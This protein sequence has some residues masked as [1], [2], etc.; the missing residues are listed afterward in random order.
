MLSRLPSCFRLPALLVLLALGGALLARP[1]QAQVQR[2]D[3]TPNPDDVPRATGAYAIEDARVVVAPGDTLEGATVVVRDGLI[4]AVGRDVDAPYDAAAVEEATG[5]EEDDS[6]VVHAGFI[7]GLSH[8]GIPQSGSSEE[9]PDVKRPGAPPPEVAGLQADRSARALLDPEE[10]T[11]EDLRA[12]GFTAAH[13][14]PRSGML[15]GQG[16]VIQLA[17]DSPSGMVLR[18]SAS[19]FA[20]FEGA[21]RVYPATDMAVIATVR[22]LLREAARRQAL[23]ERYEEAPQDLPRPRYDDLHAALS[24]VLAG[25]KPMFF[26]TDGALGL[27]RATRLHEELGFP[28]AMAGLQQ[29]F[30]ATET[31]TEIQSE[32]D[33]E[34]ADVPLFLSLALPEEPDDAPDATPDTAR[35]DSVRPG[36]VSGAVADTTQPDSVGVGQDTTKAVSP[37][38]PGSP[39]IRDYRTRSYEDTDGE[40]ENLLARRGLFAERYYANAAT[41]EDAGLQFGFSTKEADAGDIHANLRKMI[42]YGLSEED[43]LAALTTDAARLLGLSRRLGTVE[44]GKI[45]NLVVTDGALFEEDTAIR[46]VFVDGEPFEYSAE[47]AGGSEGEAPPAEGVN[48][49]GTW[50][51]EISAPGGTQTGTLTLEGAPGNLSGTIVTRGEEQTLED[52]ELSGSDLSFEFDGGQVGILSVTATIEGDTMEGLVTVPGYGGVALEGT[53]ISGPE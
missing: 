16:A 4:E 22:Q 34:T 51:I 47:P 7:S 30:A 42:E 11:L 44:E 9:E 14:V 31:L 29:S 19:V 49:A 17:G 8:A 52:V 48:P 26:F 41:L 45:A 10:N 46:H 36:A 43:A 5:V 21:G 1:T 27:H 23:G 6:L 40:R 33:A 35:A 50:E 39:F 3:E 24:P 37:Q 53:R 18:E 28:L 15:P 12:A 25:D 38:A 13:T 32:G 2:P 20:Q